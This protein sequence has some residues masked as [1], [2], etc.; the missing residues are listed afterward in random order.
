[1]I[2]YIVR[3][4]EPDYVADSLTPLGRQ[5]AQ[6]L[7]RRFQQSGL[8]RIYASPMG[9][10]RQTAQPTAD[11]LGLKI[12]IEPWMREIW[13]EL[14]LT[15][16]DGRHSFVIDMPADELRSP[17]NRRRYQDWYDMPALDSIHGRQAW[18]RVN[19]YSDDF[20]RR[21]GYRRVSEGVYSA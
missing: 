5:Q 16:P 9:R 17:E 20:L 12:K 18:E 6:A 10:A 7:V 8:D 15:L 1:M 14:A 3:H 21:L 13:P 11:A 4:G 19:R 2:L